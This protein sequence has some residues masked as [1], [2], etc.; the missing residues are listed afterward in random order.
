MELRIS[1]CRRWPGRTDGFRHPR[2]LKLTTWAHFQELE[3]TSRVAY[4]PKYEQFFSKDSIALRM[5]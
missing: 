3:L 2:L 5:K 4:E 1:I